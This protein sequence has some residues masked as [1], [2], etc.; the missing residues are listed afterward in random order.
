MARPDEGNPL[1]ESAMGGASDA[2][3]HGKH[4]AS[5]AKIEGRSPLPDHVPGDAAIERRH[6]H[7]SNY[8][9]PERRLGAGAA[10]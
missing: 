5:A 1:P 9:G 10:T 8:N 7:D 4:P 3:A 2:G 6:H